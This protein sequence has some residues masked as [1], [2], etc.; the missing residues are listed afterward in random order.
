MEIN[1]N[2][3]RVSAYTAGLFAVGVVIALVTL[4]IIASQNFVSAASDL[5]RSFSST[6]KIEPGSLVSIDKPKEGYV[7]AANTD[8]AEQLV[9]IAVLSDNSLLAVNS[10]DNK[11]QIAISG[12]ATA[13]VSNLNGD[14]KPG[15]MIAVTA[16]TGIGAKALSGARVVGISQG[17]FNSSSAGAKKITVTDTKGKTKEISIG[18]VAVVISVGTMET[19]SQTLASNSLQGFAANIAGRPVSLIR[20]AICLIIGLA[21][22]ISLV[23]V[24]NSTIRNGIAAV[25]RNPL[26]KPA[27]FDSMAQVM[28]MVAFIAVVSI[29]LMYA[30]LR[31]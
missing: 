1:K 31:I 7:T 3:E 22:I 16:F 26:A 17:S 18:A 24:V 10:S 20:V 30:V 25:A 21:A 8:N 13:L 12:Q 28:V 11:A 27:I 14:I 19:A 9:G 4:A 5:S 6:E 15:D 23:V 29:V 2:V